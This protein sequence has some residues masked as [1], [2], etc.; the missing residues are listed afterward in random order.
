MTNAVNSELRELRMAKEHYQRIL[1]EDAYIKE[2]GDI[3]GYLLLSDEDI[4]KINTKIDLISI[5]IESLLGLE[6]D[7]VEVR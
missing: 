6:K 5:K 2:S 1:K 4:A 7:Y 3:E